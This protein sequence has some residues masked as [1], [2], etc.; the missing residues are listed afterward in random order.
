M[1]AFDTLYPKPTLIPVVVVDAAEDAVPLAEVLPALLGILPVK[2][3][4]EENTPAFEAI[5][6]LCKLPYHLR[7]PM[8][9]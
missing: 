1:S 6:Q 4:Y 2:E 5:V 3:D 7:T 8:I 9:Y